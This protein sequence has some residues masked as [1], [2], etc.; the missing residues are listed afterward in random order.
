MYQNYVRERTLSSW[1]FY[2]F[3]ML[4]E[5]LLHSYN[6]NVST[7]S[8]EDLS[9]SALAWLDQHCSLNLLRPGE[10][11]YINGLNY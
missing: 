5:S 6:N 2:I 7:S 4:G 11:K 9:R 3:S 10:L 1:K 8:V